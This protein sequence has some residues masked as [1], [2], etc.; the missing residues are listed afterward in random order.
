MWKSSLS[1][2]TPSTNDIL[3]AEGSGDWINET[4]NDA[5]AALSGGGADE[6]SVAAEVAG[7]E[8]ASTRTRTGSTRDRP[9]GARA[10]HPDHTA[11][12]AHTQ[13]T[14]GEVQTWASQDP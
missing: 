12:N 10:A 1:I 6:S 11:T 2:A 8:L 7:G 5:G 14:Q 3:D 4:C 13:E 9:A